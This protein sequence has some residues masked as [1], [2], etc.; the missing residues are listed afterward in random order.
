MPRFLRING[1]TQQD[2]IQTTST[3]SA[4]ISKGGGWIV[5][6]HRFSNL[7][8][9]INFEIPFERIGYLYQELLE[10]DLL[11]ELE[12]HERLISYGKEAQ[13]TDSK[14]KGTDISGTLQVMFIHNEP[15]LERPVLAVPG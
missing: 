13:Q 1:L 6:F 11:L 9:C 4:A 10:T 12:S 3:L 7:L 5:D 15:D 14:D 8:L 2:R